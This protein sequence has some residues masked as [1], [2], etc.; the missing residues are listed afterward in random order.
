MF[1]FLKSTIKSAGK[2]VRQDPEFQKMVGRYPRFFR[3]VKKRL[4]PDEKFGLHL[5]LGVLIT[6]IFIIFFFS[7][8]QDLLQKDSLIQADLR[9]INL[10]QIFRSLSFNSFM[11]FVTNLGEGQV[12]FLGVVIAGVILAMF[13]YW[14]YLIT[15]IMSVLGGEI[16]VWAIKNI[17]ERPRPPLVNALLPESGYSF[18]SGHAF[19]ALSFYGLIIYFFYREFKS[20]ILKAMAVVSGLLII[21]AIGFSRIYLGVHWPSDVLA[22]YVSSAAWLTALIT[23]LEIRRKFSLKEKEMPYIKK[24]KLVILSMIMAGIWIVFMAYFFKTHPLKSPA[25]IPEKQIVIS[26]KDIPDNLFSIFPRTSETI[27]GGTMEPIN[28]IIVGNEQQVRKAFEKAG[29]LPT[30]PVNPR[31]VW[32]MTKAA[33]LGNS[34]PTAPG[35]PSFWNARPNDFAYEKPTEANLVSE[36]QHI[37]F[38]KTQFIFDNHEQVWFCNAHFDEKINFNSTFFLPSHSIDPAI[39]KEREKIKDDIVKTGYVE[40][41]KEFQIVEPT[42]SSNQ[43]GDQF[44]TDGKAYIVFLKG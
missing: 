17:F 8:I 41:I 43:K 39:D 33:M 11:L 14:R 16:F 37:H 36:R 9:I 28:F 3:F 40:S 23:T 6:L 29:W 27:T 2:G 1:R 34:Y 18:P 30:D 42:L 32:R 4:T 22:S 38:W 25:M 19:V 5:T 13:K 35:T 20:R 7:I 10:V 31:S 24:S 21:L 12:V 44:F 26:G 15:L